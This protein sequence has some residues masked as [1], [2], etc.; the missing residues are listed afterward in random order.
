[1]TKLDKKSIEDVLSL[2]PVQEGMLFHYLKNPAGEMHIEHVY[3]DLT[4]EID[5]EL[6]GTAWDFVVKSNEMLRTV[7]RWEEVKTPFQVILKEYESPVVFHDICDIA[8][9]PGN[10][11]PL[12]VLEEI[13]QNEREKR[14]DL[15][16]SAFRVTLCKW[17]DLDYKIIISHHHILYDGWSSGIILKEFFSSYEQAVT[18]K[19]EGKPVLPVLKQKTKYKQ[20]LELQKKR[21]THGH[22]TF[23]REYLEGLE[24]IGEHNRGLKREQAGKENGSTAQYIVKPGVE[25]NREIHRFVKQ[26]NISMASLLYSVW[27]LL[28]RHYFS[29]PDVVFDTTVSGRSVKIEGIEDMVGLFIQTLPFRAKPLEGETLLEFLSR[30]TS[31]LRT[32]GEY[33]SAF[34]AELK[35]RLE[36]YRKGTL[37]DS[38]VVIENYPLDKALLQ[39]ESSVKIRSFSGSGVTRYDLTLLVTVVDELVFHFS[40]DPQRFDEEMMAKIGDEVIY[41]LGT[42]IKKPGEIA[43]GLELKNKDILRKLHERAR[44]DH[45]RGGFEEISAGNN[46][47][48]PRDEVEE[49]LVMMW[50]ELFRV[51]PSTISI[52]TDFFDFGGHSLRAS[53]LM[54]RIN[55]EF[56]VKVPLHEIFRTP[57][58]R[59]LADYIRG[60]TAPGL[61]AALPINSD[62]IDNPPIPNTYHNQKLWEIQKPFHERVFGRRRQYLTDAI[63]PVEE[64]EY[65]PLS[66]AQQRMVALQQMAPDSIAY[67]VSYFMR[68][69]GELGEDRL[70]E[71]ERA[72]R[73]IIRRHEG[74]RTSFIMVGDTPVQKIHE[75]VE[76]KLETLDLEASESKSGDNPGPD[77][78]N[79]AITLFIRPFDLSKVPLLRIGILKINSRHH[80]LMF[81]A[82]HIICDGTSMGVF[83]REF[84]ALLGGETLLP[85]R[86]R[87]RD[88]S[89]WQNSRL[90]SE[91]MKE[92]EKYWLELFS[93]DIPVL[94]LPTDFPRVK[95]E[96]ERFK[97]SKVIHIVPQET[98]QK[99]RSL[100]RQ[101]GTTLYMI[102][103]AVTDI[104]LM[105]YSGQED[106]VVGTVT[107]GRPHPD[108][109]NLVGVLITTLAARNFP[110]R[111]KPF[112]H[113]LQEVKTAGLNAIEHSEYPFEELLKHVK[114]ERDSSR[115]PLFD[116]MFLLQNYE[117][118]EI[119]LEGLRFEPY[120]YHADASTF[121]LRFTAMENPEGLE[122]EIQYA[123]GL[124]K[125]STVN[126][127]CRHFIHLLDQVGDHRLKPLGHLQLLDE[128]EKEQVL[129]EFNSTQ[130]DTGEMKPV[131]RWFEDEAGKR[132]SDIAL[133]DSD[134]EISYELLNERVNRLAHFLRGRGVVNGQAVGVMLPP[135]PR[136]IE[137]L[138]AVWKAGGAYIP[139]DPRYPIQRIRQLAGDSGIKILLSE[140][141]ALMPGVEDFF[142]GNL[143]VLDEA[144][145]KEA[146]NRESPENPVHHIDMENPAYIIYT[147]GSTGKP[148][149]AGVVHRGF[150]NLMK[151]FVMEF[152]LEPSDSNLLVT[153][154]S[155]DLT[156]KNLFASLLTGGKLVLPPMDYFDPR[157]IVQW[158]E[159]YRITWINCT[160]SM[161]SRLIEFCPDE[162]FQKL[163]SL[164]YVFLGGEPIAMSIFKRWT[165]PGFCRAEVVNTYGPTECTDIC[166]SYRVENPAGYTEAS[167]PT[168]KPVYNVR[169]YV[170]DASLQPVPCGVPGE[171]YIAGEGVGF[172]YI[173]DIPGTTAK[174]ISS[175]F[176]QESSQTPR[177]YR[178]G[179]LVKWSNDESGNIEFI[180][181]VD[182]Q[183]K[184]RGFRIEL[185]EIEAQLAK[186]P[187]ITKAA[188]MARESGSKNGN[189]N[190]NG[191]GNGNGNGNGGEPSDRYLCAY[192]TSDEHPDANELKKYLS[193]HLPGYM[194]PSFIIQLEKFPLSPN[195]KIDYKSLPDPRGIVETHHGVH[196]D[197]VE[198]TLVEIWS[199]V[200]G[201]EEGKIGIDDNFFQLGGHSLKMAR[202]MGRIEKIFHI[203]IPIAELFKNP[204]VRELHRCLQ[205]RERRFEGSVEPA[206][207]K[208]YYP[209]ST[210]QKRF[211]IFQHMEPSSISY[212]MPLY[213]HIEGDLSK[214]K[215]E[216]IFRTLIHRHESYRTVFKVVNGVPAQQVL[217]TAGFSIPL[218]DLSTLDISPRKAEREKHIA[219]FVRPFDLEKA[220]LMRIELIKEEKEKHILLV[221]HHHIITDGVSVEIII[222]ECLDLY[223]GKQLPPLHTLYRDY[224]EWAGM[225]KKNPAVNYRR[226]EADEGDPEEVL[227]IP[228]DYPRSESQYF[229]ARLITFSAQ[230][231]EKE[232]LLKLALEYDSTLYMVLLSIFTVFL[233]KLCGQENIVVGSPIA[234]RLHY[235]LER[236]VGL[237]INTVVLRNFPRGEK[238][239]SDYLTEVKDNALDV[240]EN[241]DFQYDEL[242]EKN[243]T[244]KELN[245]NPLFDVMLALQNM[246]IPEITVPGLKINQGIIDKRGSKFDV[247]LYCYENE[248][249][250]FE[251]EYS[252]RLFKEETAVRFTRCFKQ[253]ITAVVK[254]P[255]RLLS[256]VEII[257]DDEKMRI[258]IDFN[259]SEVPYAR[260]KTVIQVIEEQV[261]KTPDKIALHGNR[262]GEDS[263]VSLTY[264][265]LNLRCNRLAFFL[266]E[267]GVK[268]GTVVG[269]M[270]DRSVDAVISVLSVLKAGGGYVPIDS[271]YPDARIISMLESSGAPIILTHSRIFES[272]SILPQ[273]PGSPLALSEP[274]C[275]KVPTPPKTFN[276]V[277]NQKLLQG[278]RGRFST[279]KAPQDAESNQEFVFLDQIQDLLETK[280][281]ENLTPISGPA[282]L[283][284]IIFTSGS[285]GKPKGAGVYHRGFMNLVNWFTVEFHMTPND[286]TLLITS[287]SFDLT[288]KIIF[289]PLS[290]AGTLHLSRSP[291]FDPPYILGEI[292]SHRATWLNCT[293]SMFYRLVE[294]DRTTGEK[295]L[296]SIKRVFLGGEPIAIN[297]MLDWLESEGK[298]VEIVNTYGPTECADVSTYFRI[299]NPRQYLEKA[300]PLGIPVYNVELWVI[301]KHLALQPI[302]VPGELAVGGE[303]VGMGYVNEK[304]M[305]DRAFK[306]CSFKEGEPQRS[307][308]RTG[309]LAKWLPDG[310][311]EFLGRIDHQVKIRGFRIEIGEIENRLNAYP[312]INECLVMVK[313]PKAG[314]KYLCAY[315]VLLEAARYDEQELRD[316]MAE[317]L[318]DYM[319]PSYFILLEKMPLNPNGKVD[320]KALPEPT[321]SNDSSRV[322][323]VNEIEQAMT[324]VWGEVLGKDIQ[325]IGVLD[326]FF[327]LGGHSLKA[328]ELIAKIHKTFSV[329]L[330]IT[331]VLKNPTIR[332]ICHLISKTRQTAFKPITPAEH[333]EFYP[334]SA[335]QRRLYFLHHLDKHGTGYNIPFQFLIEGDLDVQRMEEAFRRLIH[336]HHSLRTSFRMSDS[337]PVQYIHDR[338]DFHISPYNNS[339]NNSHHPKTLSK[340]SKSKA[341]G[342]PKT[343]SRKGFWPSE[344]NITFDFIAPFD[345]ETPPLFRVGMMKT[346]ENAHILFVDMHHII[347]DGVSISQ[348]IRDFSHFYTGEKLSPLKLQYTDYA[349]WQHTSHYAD[350]LSKQ[351]KYWLSV[352]EGEL[353]VLD[354]L[355]DFPRPPMQSFEGN[356]LHFTIDSDRTAALKELALRENTTLYTVLF[357]IFYLF[358]FK[359]RRQDPGSDPIVLGTVTAGRRHA[360]LQSVIGM[361]VN[362]LAVRNTPQSE[363][364]FLSFLDEVKENTLA[365]FENQEYPYETLLEKLSLDRNLGRNP[366][367]DVMFSLQNFDVPEIQLEGLAI[368]PHPCDVGISKF[369]LSLDGNEAGSELSMR[370]EYCTRLFKEETI[371]RF[372]R[373]IRQA[374]ASVLENPHARIRDI[375]II[376]EEERQTVLYKFNDTAEQYPPTRLVHRL[377]EEVVEEKP[378]AMA[379]VDEYRQMTYTEL[380]RRANRVASILRTNGVRPGSIVRIMME[381][382]NELMVALLG[383][384][385]SGGAYLPV[386]PFSP[387]ERASYMKC[388][389]ASSWVL[390]QTHLV[391]RLNDEP[392]LLV[393]DSH[394]PLS[395]EGDGSNLPIVNETHDPAYVIYTSGSTGKPKGAIAMH[396]GMVNQLY[397]MSR[398]YGMNHRDVVLQK[399]AITFDVSML[400]LF[401][402]ILVGGVL[403]FLGA[404]DEKDPDV[405][406]KTVERH[407]V[408][409][410]DYSP[411]VLSVFLDYV[412]EQEMWYKLKTL[413][414]IFTG[415]ETVSSGLVKRFNKNLY[416]LYG[417]RLYNL[418]GLTETTAD[419][420]WFDCTGIE[421]LDVVPI[422]K[423]LANTRAYILDPYN[424]VQPIGVAGEL[425]IAGAHI[426]R[427]Y[428]NQVE[429]TAQSFFIDPLRAWA[430]AGPGYSNGAQKSSGSGNIDNSLIPNANNK[431]KLSEIQ[432]PFHERV[433]GRRR[434]VPGDRM[435]KTGDLARWSSDGNIEYLGRLVHQIKI[436]GMRVEPGEI[437]NR[438]LSYDKIKEAVVLAISDTPN[439]GTSH[440]ESSDKYLCAYIVP[441]PSAVPGDTVID[442]PDLK[443]FLSR[444]LPDYMIPTH[445]VQLDRV[446]LTVNGKLDRKALPHPGIR[447]SKTTLAPVT[448]IQQKLAEIWSDVLLVDKE[449]I[450]ID[451]DFFQLGGHS[452]KAILVLSKIHKVFNVKVPLVEI[453]SHPTIQSL[454]TFIAASGKTRYADIRPAPVKEYYPLSSEQ[455]RLYI[456]Q[457][458]DPDSAGYNMPDF[459]QFNG[460]FDVEKTARVFQQLVDRHEALR[461]AFIV[462]DGEPV[463]HIREAAQLKVEYYEESDREK[464][465][466]IMDRFVRAFALEYPP[467][468]RVGIVRMASDRHL[469]MVDTHHI[470]ADAVSFDILKRDFLA[471]YD[472]NSL[473]PL[474]LHY[475]D[476]SQWQICR[477]ESE[478]LKSQEKYWLSQ[479]EKE[480]VPLKLP[481]DYPRP[482]IRSFAGNI[483][484]FELDE[485]LTSK[486]REFVTETRTTFYIVLQGI[487][488]VLLY[489]YTGQEDI[490]VGSPI[491]IRNH[492]DLQDII[493]TFVNMLAMRN[494][495]RPGIPFH[496]FLEEV[497]TNA[498]NGYENQDYPFEELVAKLNPRLDPSRN[499]L[500]DVA[501]NV[502]DTPVK[503]AQDSE[504]LTPYKLEHKT[505]KYDLF[506]RAIENRDTVEL[507][508][509][510]STTLFSAGTISKMAGHYLEILRQVLEDRTLLIK[511]IVISH[512]LVL[513]DNVVTGEEVDFVF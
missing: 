185:G 407:G 130:V 169:L 250:D 199:E 140:K 299:Q 433:F 207:D 150:F 319:I 295:R 484:R 381:R 441:A 263:A 132:G 342:N 309:D 334:L 510:Y 261:E 68:I 90:L 290:S 275:K 397:W 124:F 274:F 204:T 508:L 28:L 171:L 343:L 460:S 344:T 128:K 448:G 416:R 213:L 258:L 79:G 117:W 391:D 147:S 182:H 108:L 384:L 73:E 249:L 228:L 50:G 379:V 477:K 376:P 425:C 58:I 142:E 462:M 369:D 357:A 233:S 242:V 74:L 380:N 220:P 26:N 255:T 47:A 292:L 30:N 360:D 500:A 426:T 396:C 451:S 105:K 288:Q 302:G 9:K 3:L 320:R 472:G 236:V 94:N 75:N 387:P 66:H 229:E 341:L 495:P 454:E 23:W 183:V 252:S 87:Y 329:E 6:F 127:L 502:I 279:K 141:S 116:T 65:Y 476:Y 513:A 248:L 352:F 34:P 499:S 218:T 356:T 12:V 126:R 208:E 80:V 230:P 186:H 52:D 355:T 409:I 464:I 428:I 244:A 32:W 370:F 259:R 1:M 361:F 212:N 291:I 346:Q 330:P 419:V 189:G 512:E 481:T 104:L 237:F 486:I 506:L 27:G 190:G 366:L 285:T 368:K 324:A 8:G 312:S 429:M 227:N 289:G 46:Y 88:F 7:F 322:L 501:L 256:S 444:S 121:D 270:I 340:I 156:Q 239:F 300:V 423:P 57:T 385:K 195:G 434:Q 456:L 488:N 19:K 64:K 39:N 61:T 453:F 102:L 118:N 139:I 452:L 4:G 296:A 471:L 101:T 328:A 148:K 163:I 325:A 95:L 149:G 378:D 427:G 78:V 21:D 494:N 358:L 235:D 184:I 307:I 201:I 211:F 192:Y 497:K 424:N 363:K 224:V 306:R 223:V 509:E 24:G 468:L 131:C 146:I 54:G 482:P 120:P 20:Y 264:R 56:N 400:E 365:A 466:K 217:E 45:E 505:A 43:A 62:H 403:C 63:E 417:T 410:I 70:K 480:V 383:I 157:V 446:P 194:V 2:S 33:E 459:F 478:A 173:N 470:A 266:R 246:G 41:F 77:P 310:T 25:F 364:L 51:D 487:F 413:R 210:I 271:A 461:T 129:M 138:L 450:G 408:T 314:D 411:S 262:S 449:R 430:F 272:K 507:S 219:G 362:T 83:A 37:F 337:G 353:P 332:G 347:A 221:D 153:S 44:W 187:K 463:Q 277:Y 172:G 55:Q 31:E 373:Y 137:G 181:R 374:V 92:H 280:P 178:T 492:E 415:S 297:M 216:T 245:R 164:R 109:E 371:N 436:R 282:D 268:A 247:T 286:R 165:D 191:H 53:R 375:D 399:T 82:H 36:E 96:E 238:R 405:V 435:Y 335:G 317:G 490:V 327:K 114:F 293:P 382:S 115:N 301:D 254:D 99:L 273:S 151:W 298:G 260:E 10:R 177:I 316:Y 240:F 135:G 174:F 122:I 284:Y 111:D 84:M 498:L 265:E 386:D 503:D 388:D 406:L 60:K 421:G 160:P 276:K 251:W 283:I 166:A 119:K 170:L 85:P 112:V 455:M 40:Y 15:A 13:V 232:A 420:T 479:F 390:T 311:L 313:E 496:R 154:L 103:L 18:Q 144:E 14:F 152:R 437:E 269:Y 412:E 202:L 287:L 348:L 226:R 188:V 447:E 176:E 67:N 197:D 336:R 338:V 38:V 134:E 485:E 168:G 110:K 467:M 489:K 107:D 203:K 243:L 354:I 458:M 278:D 474:K 404:G 257:P 349:V 389:S 136:V 155:F 49:K 431:Q 294:Y 98:R 445:V 304:E 97:G 469:L 308:Y 372:I 209:L 100:E 432:K 167:V 321:V 511:D 42:I 241:Q 333:S 193:R 71:M 394:N 225:K 5:L 16:K 473:P 234:G 395:G 11:E 326:N 81:D 303:G 323:P 267:K 215:L 159:Q 350:I 93:G 48:A 401:R 206:E 491:T 180:G 113:F 125:E 331:A 439:P 76:F 414:V 162:D 377:F 393:L 457:Q 483:H 222:R 493:G 133:I 196:L 253:V 145:T 398:M 175:P 504:R 318:P 359:I 443:R 17:G 475:K 231:G 158:I 106:I 367:F 59:Q 214:E 281:G 200:L 72:F 339:H 123:G 345:L 392:F 179:D 305:T 35:D 91:T 402:W 22:E 422:G 440:A 161:I 86:T 89:Q 143:L 438:L 418:Y 198:S 29:S 442:I 69:E 351:E 205:M 465:E 315:I